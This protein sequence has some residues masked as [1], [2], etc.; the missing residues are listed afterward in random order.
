MRNNEL[1]GKTS[2]ERSAIMATLTEEGYRISDKVE[3]AV[4]LSDPQDR[5][6]EVLSTLRTKP[7]KVTRVKDLFTK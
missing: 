7:G 3:T 4:S 6:N 2:G 1:Q 5:M